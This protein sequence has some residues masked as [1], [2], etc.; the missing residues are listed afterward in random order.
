MHREF[1][2]CLTISKAYILAVMPHIKMADRVPYQLIDVYV[3]G[4]S[5]LLATTNPIAV[6]TTGVTTTLT[7]AD[8][9]VSVRRGYASPDRRLG[10]SRQTRP[11]S[12]E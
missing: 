2:K 11:L 9:N 6:Q 8:P 1:K 10:R 12:S 5:D 4:V 3:P 7:R